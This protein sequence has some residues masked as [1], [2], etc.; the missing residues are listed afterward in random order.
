[1]ISR[2]TG[3]SN[4]GG[5]FNR[6]P[7]AQIDDLSEAVRH[8]NLTVTQHSSKFNAGSLAYAEVDGVICSTGRI[9]GR[10]ALQGPLSCDVVS[11]GLGLS[12]PPGNRQWLLEVETGELGVF[13]AGDEHD[14]LYSEG[15]IYAVASLSL[16][17]LEDFAAEE[18]IVL[19]RT[20][21]GGTGIHARKMA[22]HVLAH[23]RDIFDLIHS[24]A[25]NG[26]G[27]TRELLSAIIQHLGRP[28]IDLLRRT[29]RNRYDGVFLRARTYINDNL[30]HPMSLDEI[31]RAANTSRRTLCRAFA[32]ILDVTPQ[33]YVRRLRLHRIRQNLAGDVERACTITIIA[34]NW[35]VSELGRFAKWYH[36]LFGELPSQT[37]KRSRAV[38]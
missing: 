8:A 10:V 30:S 28:P 29:S 27:A 12:L 20:T 3:S 25:W 35:G 4:D 6:V 13:H 17:L 22:P 16:D 9:G 36:D 24:G 1:M 38:A 14:A 31:A 23:L 18:D 26:D 33:A 5:I 2:E 11:I 32:D 7:I 34:N 19:D 15:S 37:L 21:L